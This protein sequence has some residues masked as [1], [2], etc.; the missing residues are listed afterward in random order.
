VAAVNATAARH[1]GGASKMMTTP[2]NSPWISER[3]SRIPALTTG[4]CSAFNALR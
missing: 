4:T 2:V 3:T 1:D